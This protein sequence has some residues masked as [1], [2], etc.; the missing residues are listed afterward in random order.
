MYRLNG[1][2]AECLLLFDLYFHFS[3]LNIF[4]EKDLRVEKEFFSTNPSLGK[5]DNKWIVGTLLPPPENDTS[6]IE[7]RDSSF[8]TVFFFFLR[9]L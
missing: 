9:N 6:L 4:E 7:V 3:Y 2:H 5:F 1:T 8:L